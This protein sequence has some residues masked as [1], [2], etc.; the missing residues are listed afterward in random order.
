MA[1]ITFC[2]DLSNFQVNNIIL[3]TVVT[4][5]CIT[6][7]GFIEFI[8]GNMFLWTP[9]THFIHPLVNFGNRQSVS[10][11]H[12]SSTLVWQT[13][14]H[15][16]MKLWALLRRA[17]QDGRVTVESSDK[18]WSSGGGNGKPLQYYCCENTMNSMKRQKYTT[19]KNESPRSLQY[20]T[21]EEQRAI[22]N[23]SRKSEAAGPKQTWIWA[24]SRR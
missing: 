5:L 1:A 23:S 8:T 21:G 2:S 3:L 13:S 4:I 9:F 20:V 19:P 10:L 16:I 11:L 17:T 22:T 24:N 15:N 12:G 6:S 14:F 18:T 7:L